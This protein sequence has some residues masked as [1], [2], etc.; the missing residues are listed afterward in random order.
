MHDAATR[1]PRGPGRAAHERG[2]RRLPGSGR[3]ARAAGRDRDGLLSGPLA[4]RRTRFRGPGSRG[5]APLRRG[6]PRRRRPPHRVRRRARRCG[7][8][9]PASA[10][11]ARNGRRAAC[12]RR[13]GH[14]AAERHRD[15]QRQPVVRADPRARRAAPDHDLPGLGAHAD[16]AHRARRP[17]GLSRGRARPAA[18]RQPRFRGRR[19]GRRVVRRDH[20][21]V[22]AATGSPAPARP[23][24]RCSRRACRASGSA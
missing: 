8:P 11:P 16:A 7:R 13:A 4:G 9:L 1:R 19:R 14:R 5:G 21:R 15:R 6:R 10:Q 12:V 22:R 24:C 17:G 18:R 20:A 3:A 2:L 23:R